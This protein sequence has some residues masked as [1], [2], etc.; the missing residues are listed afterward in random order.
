[1]D[2]ASS[3]SDSSSSWDDTSYCTTPEGGWGDGWGWGNFGGGGWG[4]PEGGGWSPP[5]R[6]AEVLLMVDESK[7][8]EEL[9]V[10]DFWIEA[11]ALIKGDDIDVEDPLNWDTVM[12]ILPDG[13]RVTP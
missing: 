13:E 2:T 5:P 6:R 8:P 12:V 10:G 3:S 9:T 4:E 7:D 11:S 1:M